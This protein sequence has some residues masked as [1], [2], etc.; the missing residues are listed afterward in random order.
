MAYVVFWEKPGC[1]GN[2]KQQD[3]L[4]ASGHLLELRNLLIERWTVETLQLFFG[5]RPVAEWFNPS[6][7]RVKCGEIR[8]AELA[9]GQAL[10]MMV[11]EPLLIVRPLMQVGNQRLAGFEVQQ[12][13]NWIGLE[14]AAIG[15]RNPQHCPCVTVE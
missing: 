4:L 8:P 13:H 5:E 6:N 9:P 11:E 10:A 7:P 2:E 12:V 3:I 14:L 15:P 1:K